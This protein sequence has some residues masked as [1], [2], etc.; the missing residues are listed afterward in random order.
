[1]T[2]RRE[3]GGLFLGRIVNSESEISEQCGDTAIG[4]GLSGKF[5]G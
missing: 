5:R 4:S 3:S 2:D 1:M